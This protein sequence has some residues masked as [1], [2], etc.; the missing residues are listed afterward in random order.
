[1]Y[2][3]FKVIAG[4]EKYHCPKCK[5]IYAGEILSSTHTGSRQQARKF[6]TRE[7]RTVRPDDYRV[8]P[9]SYEVE[10]DEMG[11]VQVDTYLNKAKC[12][13]CSHRWE[14]NSKSEARVR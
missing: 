3:F 14:F 11:T 10:K 6:R 4:V 7:R 8:K 13:R 12:K 5:K 1:M 2:V 9:Y